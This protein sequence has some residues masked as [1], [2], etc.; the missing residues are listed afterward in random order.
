MKQKTLNNPAQKLQLSDRAIAG[1]SES[2]SVETA[3]VTEL[4]QYRQQKKTLFRIKYSIYLTPV[5]ES[6]SIRH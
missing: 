6:V 1:L 3:H 5:V 2:A 4:L